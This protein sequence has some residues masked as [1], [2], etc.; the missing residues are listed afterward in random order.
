MIIPI[1]LMMATIRLFATEPWRINCFGERILQARWQR[2]LAMFGLGFLLVTTTACSIW[3]GYAGRYE[4]FNRAYSEDGVF[5]DIHSW[6]TFLQPSDVITGVV[7]VGREQRWLPEAYLYGFQFTRMYSHSRSAFFLGEFGLDGWWTFFPYC[8]LVK[9][10]IGTLLLLAFAGMAWLARCKE[11]PRSE[12][13][14]FVRSGLY[15]TTPLWLLFA[16]YCSFAISS[17]LNIGHRHLLPVEG[18]LLMFAGSAAWWWQGLRSTEAKIKNEAITTKS[19]VSFARYRWRQSLIA[20]LTLG[21][22]IATMLAAFMAWPN[23]LAFFNC[24]DGGPSQAWKKLNDSSLDWGQELPSL[25]AWLK[26]ESRRNPSETEYYL[27]Y[28]GTA[29]PRYHGINATLLPGYVDLREWS[30]V[31]PLRPGVY[32]ISATMLQ[33]NYTDFP[34]PWSAAYEDEFQSLRN[35]ERVYLDETFVSAWGKISESE[36]F[37]WLQRFRKFEQARFARLTHTLRRRDPDDHVNYGIL[38]YRV[39]ADELSRALDGPVSK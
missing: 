6:E 13:W 29:V 31:F 17:S 35:V 21:C 26:R 37:E 8:E 2:L 22:A 11:R 12:R 5:K 38:I 39:S 19:N 23:Y 9:T 27:S 28:F 36:R 14:T 16:C 32:C 7:R 33:G 4:M 3:L 18:P 20:A 10:P 30:A 34:G 24:L 25:Q 1:G 15:W